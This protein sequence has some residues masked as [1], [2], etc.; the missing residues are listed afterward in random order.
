MELR[1]ALD[2]SVLSETS[3]RSPD[4]AVVAWLTRLRRAVVPMGAIIEL[5]QGIHM[6][7]RYDLDGALLLS[8][9]LADLLAS[10]IRVVETDTNVSR[11]Y[12]EMRACIALRHLEATRPDSDK[13]GGQDLHIAAAAIV[14]GLCI[15]T[16]NIRDFLLIHNHFKLPGLYDPKHDHWYVYPGSK[17]VQLRAKLPEQS[18]S[19][20]LMHR[21]I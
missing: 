14:H 19:S 2:T 9:W 20:N 15:A 3:K 18:R 10:G 4:L 21:K 13:L 8:Q 11:K 5:E 1:Y 6:R 16:V 17:H 7:A 12:G